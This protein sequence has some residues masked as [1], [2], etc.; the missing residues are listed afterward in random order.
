MNHAILGQK[1]CGNCG[2]R[3]VDNGQLVCALNPPQT[4]P[5]VAYKQVTKTY[6]DGR[7]ESTM[8]PFVSGFANAFPGVR[9]EQRCGKHVTEIVAA[10]SLDNLRAK[11]G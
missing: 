8:M 9:A 4:F 2:V 10:T 5:I 11:V 6:P 1:T 7:E 3:A